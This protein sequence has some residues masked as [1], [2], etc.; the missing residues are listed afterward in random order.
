M[1]AGIRNGEAR[2]S[3]IRFFRGPIRCKEIA[4]AAAIA[5]GFPDGNCQPAVLAVAD[6]VRRFHGPGKPEG[7]VFYR[8]PI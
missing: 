4:I 1:E 3:R 6:R 8:S 7:R 5:D 2:N